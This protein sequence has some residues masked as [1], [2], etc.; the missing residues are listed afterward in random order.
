MTYSHRALVQF[1]RYAVIIPEADAYLG[2]CVA[3]FLLTGVTPRAPLLVRY[4]RLTPGL[5]KHLAG[6]HARRK[7]P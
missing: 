2:Q 7:V 5:L 3:D 4:R 1:F 6:L